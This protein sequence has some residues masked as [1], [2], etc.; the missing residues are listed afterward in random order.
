MDPGQF[1]VALLNLAF[2][3]RD[4]MPSGGTL[5]I[6]TENIKV[7]G[8][9]GSTREGVPPGDYVCVT[10]S[11]TGA[12]MEEEAQRRAFEPFFTTKAAGK[13]S[14]LGLSMVYG[15]ARQSDGHILI[16]SSL[17]EG[18]SVKL[19][20]PRAAK[21]GGATFF[22]PQ[23]V[24]QPD[25]SR[26]GNV[27]IVEDDPLVREH[28][29]Q[30]FHALGYTVSLAASAEEALVMLEA[31]PG[32]FMLF[33][34][35]V[36]GAGMNGLELALEA[37]RRRPGLKVLYTSGYV[38][39]EIGFNGALVPDAEMLRKPYERHE[40]IRKLSDVQRGGAPGG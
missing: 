37:R 23:D 12:G 19:F 6:E 40:L 30:N 4:A 17:G 35:V 7:R 33:T 26:T 32:I 31:D 39:G 10:V 11:D 16:S 15:F 25:L 20:F 14:G 24:A 21:D 1:D 18:T 13:G 2:N 38:P 29:A 28:S 22:S 36:L 27:L 3:A 5:T 8:R 9:S 34:D